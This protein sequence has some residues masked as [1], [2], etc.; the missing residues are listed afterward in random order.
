MYER[1]VRRQ[2]RGDEVRRI[3]AKLMLHYAGLDRR[4]NAGIEKFEAALK[5]ARVDYTLH[6]YE[7]VHHAFHNNTSKARYNATAARR[8]WLRTIAFLKQHLET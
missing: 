7:G 3:K 6:M 8:A 5:K 1:H 2:P 4:I